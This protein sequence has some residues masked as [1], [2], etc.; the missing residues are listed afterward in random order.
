MYALYIF[1]INQH[2]WFMHIVTKGSLITKTIQKWTLISYVRLDKIWCISSIWVNLEDYGLQLQFLQK[3]D[4][5]HRKNKKKKECIPRC[6]HT[7][8]SAYM[9]NSICMQNYCLNYWINAAKHGGDPSAGLLRCSGIPGCF[10]SG[11]QLICMVEMNCSRTWLSLSNHLPLPTGG[12][13][14]PRRHKEKTKTLVQE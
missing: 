2:L 10:K 1:I 11:L 6:W 5:D 12:W 14:R 9:L 8:K 3:C 4:K 7:E 13:W